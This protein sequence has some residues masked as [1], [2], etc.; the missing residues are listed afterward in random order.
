[1]SH[2]FE[3]VN[4]SKNTKLCITQFYFQKLG[5]DSTVNLQRFFLQ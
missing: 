4:T 1:M 3:C 2:F 5:T